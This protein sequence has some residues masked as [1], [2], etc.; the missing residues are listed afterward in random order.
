MTLKKKSAFIIVLGL[1]LLASNVVPKSMAVNRQIDRQD[2][3]NAVGVNVAVTTTTL[4]DFVG[5]IIGKEIEPIINPG[6]CP[7]HYDSEP[8]DIALVQDADIVFCHGF[9]G[10]WLDDLLNSVNKSSAKYPLSPLVAGA[11]WGVPANAIKYLEVITAMLNNTYAGL[12]SQFNTNLQTYSNQINA[13]A[14]ELQELAQNYSLLHKKAVVMIHQFGFTSFLGLDVVANWS[15]SDELMSVQE[16][17][18]LITE[19][20]E[21]QAEIVISNLQSG[22]NVGEE[23]ANEL[24]IPHAILTNFPQNDPE[25][26]NYLSMLEY[27]L[28]QIRQAFSATGNSAN[29]A[30]GLFVG[31]ASIIIIAPYFLHQEK[32]NKQKKH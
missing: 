26:A 17:A 21:A 5:A 30:L 3:G 7:A 29:S 25:A 6:T 14:L 16:V 15:K 10:Q 22:T 13:K 2:V 8:G 4:A 20:A 27:N 12:A 24:G 1:L 11:P 18:A 19:A 28:E 31:L 23:I 32:R 9:E